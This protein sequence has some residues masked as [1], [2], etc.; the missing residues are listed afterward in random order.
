MSKTLKKVST[1][2]NYFEHLINSASTVTQCVFISAFA[3]L[4]G[5]LLGITSSAVGLKICAIT[6]EL[7]SINQWLR[8]KEK[9]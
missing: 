6:Q 2:S 5:I 7:K 1:T 8:Q 4:F 9:R 3:S